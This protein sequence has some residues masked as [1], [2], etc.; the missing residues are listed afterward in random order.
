M[1]VENTQL[2]PLKG[3]LS[4][5]YRLRDDWFDNLNVVGF[6]IGQKVIS[7]QPD[8][9]RAYLNRGIVIRTNNRLSGEDTGGAT[10]GSHRGRSI[11]KRIR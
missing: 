7:L 3:E 9:P 5:L 2:Y 6:H 4:G 8:F 1:N 10:G 11:N